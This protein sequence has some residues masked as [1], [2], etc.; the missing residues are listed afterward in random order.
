M[1]FLDIS[2]P[3]LVQLGEQK[4]KEYTH[5]DPFPKHLF[6]Q[7]FQRRRPAAGAG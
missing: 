1:Q 2:I 3:E 4:Q 5:A 6:R 7:L